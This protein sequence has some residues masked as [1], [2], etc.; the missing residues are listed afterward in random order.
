MI[1]ENIENIKELRD[2]GLSYQKIGKIYGVSRQRIHQCINKLGEI[3]NRDYIMLQNYIK[4]RDGYKCRSCGKRILSKLVIHHVDGNRENNSKLNLMTL[5]SS[6]HC[7]IH[8]SK[9]I[10]KLYT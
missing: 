10:K 7:S 8:S 4:E 1:N 3:K 2:N 5:C 6:C 9:R